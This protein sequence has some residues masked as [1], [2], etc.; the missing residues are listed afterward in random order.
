MATTSQKMMEIRFLVR[1]RGALTPP[2]RM[3]EPVMKMPL[4]DGHVESATSVSAKEKKARRKGKG[5]K[6]LQQLIGLC[7]GRCLGLPRYMV[8]LFRGSGRPGEW[9]ELTSDR[10]EEMPVD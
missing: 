9:D 1:I 10:S 3:E 5:T 4:F 8:I 7:R 6:Q 2:P